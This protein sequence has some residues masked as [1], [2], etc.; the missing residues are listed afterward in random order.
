MTQL[1]CQPDLNDFNIK[2]RSNRKFEHCFQATDISGT[3]Q[4]CLGTSLCKRVVVQSSLAIVQGLTSD[5]LPP[6]KELRS[7]SKWVFGVGPS[8]TGSKTAVTK[9]VCSSLSVRSS[10]QSASLK[11]ENDLT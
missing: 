1:D 10:L 9:D 4:K 2:I 8:M 5:Q 6:M 11:Y 7:V 3:V